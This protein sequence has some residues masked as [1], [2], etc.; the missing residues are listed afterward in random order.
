MVIWS[1]VANTQSAVIR[2]IRVISAV[3][4]VIRVIR[5]MSAVLKIYLVKALELLFFQ[6]HD[7]QHVVSLV[8][9]F[10]N[11]KIGGRICEKQNKQRL[12]SECMISK[13]IFLKKVL[14]NGSAGFSRLNYSN[15]KTFGGIEPRTLKS[16][17]WV[18]TTTVTE[19]KTWCMSAVVLSEA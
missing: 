9:V 13:S 12:R 19:E 3:I 5:M 8:L 17:L 2:V 4:R 6:V 11:N 14:A 10:N 18:K 7:V 15:S 1:D 16:L